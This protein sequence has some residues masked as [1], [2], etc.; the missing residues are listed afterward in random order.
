VTRFDLE[1][2]SPEPRFESLARLYQEMVS[3]QANQGAPDRQFQRDGSGFVAP[4]QPGRPRTQSL[5]H[6]R[7]VLQTG[8]RDGLAMLT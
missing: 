3:F 4:R 6:C 5:D 8:G 2:R 7:Q 1:A